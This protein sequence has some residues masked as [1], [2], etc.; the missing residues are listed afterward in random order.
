MEG[1]TDMNFV[2]LKFRLFD[3]ALVA[4]NW[5]KNAKWH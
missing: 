5:L 3:S 4:A 1:G 2:F